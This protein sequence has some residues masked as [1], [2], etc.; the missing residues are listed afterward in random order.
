MLSRNND[1]SDDFYYELACRTEE[2][3]LEDAK[4]SMPSNDEL[5]AMY[6]FSEGFEKKM[7]LL[8]GRFDR[9]RA[10]SRTVKR[11]IVIAAILAALIAGA[12]SVSAIRE[13][14]CELFVKDLGGH[15]VATYRE[16]SGSDR[17]RN[18]SSFTD[19]TVYYELSYLPEGF[20][21]AGRSSVASQQVIKYRRGHEEILFVQYSLSAQMLLNRIGTEIHTVSVNEETAYYT[22]IN[23]IV[24]LVWDMNGYS[25]MLDSELSVEESVKIAENIAI[26][27]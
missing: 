19:I 9:R 11:I 24:V 23:D 2:I 14:L 18:N 12:L 27:N 10:I 26:S 17:V 21:E 8:I 25:Y 4:D 22:L 3:V 1:Y 6:T 16:V 5:K 15:A 7:K 20:S 13:K